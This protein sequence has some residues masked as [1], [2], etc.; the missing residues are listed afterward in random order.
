M[1]MNEIT[2]LNRYKWKKKISCFVHSSRFSS[3]SLSPLPSFVT[4]FFFFNKTTRSLCFNE[5]KRTS[6]ENETRERKMNDE[7]NEEISIYIFPYF[8]LINLKEGNTRHFIP[9]FLFF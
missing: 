6:E 5:E 3:F 7:T 1:G 9:C 8:S 2:N 4:R